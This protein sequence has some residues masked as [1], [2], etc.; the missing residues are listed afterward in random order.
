MH[1]KVKNW[2][3]RDRDFEVLSSEQKNIAIST[4]NQD[5]GVTVPFPPGNFLFRE[6]NLSSFS[7][8][9]RPQHAIYKRQHIVYAGKN[10]N[11]LDEKR[12]VL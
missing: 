11:F 6:K 2:I 5:L 7:L 8:R 12:H 1:K 10:G 9:R 3:I 4:V